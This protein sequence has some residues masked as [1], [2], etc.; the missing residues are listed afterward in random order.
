M[1]LIR[2]DGNNEIGTGHVMRCLSIAAQAER[3]EDVLFVVADDRS[4]ELVLKKGFPCVVLNTDY[5]NMEA[6]LP[7]LFEL[8]RKMNSK[9][10]LVDSYQITE[11]YLMKLSSQVS[12]CLIEDFM[13]T[14]HSVDVLVNYNIYADS[15]AYQT[16]YQMELKRRQMQLLLGAEYSP[17]REQ[18][19]EV[20]YTVNEQVRNVLITTGGS[21]PLQMGVR[22]LKE[23]LQKYESREL[24]YH[25]LSGIFDRSK[26]ELYQI[27]SRNKQVTVHENVT[28]M[29]ELMKSCDIAI[30]AAGTT[31]YELSAVG[32]PT[33]AYA[34][35]DNQDQVAEEFA[36][37]HM[38]LYAG[39]S[40]TDDVMRLH[41]I[42]KAFERML[43]DYD[44]RCEL[45]MEMKKHVDGA[46]ARKIYHTLYGGNKI[47]T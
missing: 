12:V 33:I 31:M 29:A 26:E 32:I 37:E 38:A 42:I 27:A 16:L 2:T 24:S 6:E 47:E 41:D 11:E 34:F 19:Q 5:T 8:I 1:I 13:T 35:V 15:E 39:G 40:K 21:D 10:I 17:L 3:K 7:L 45:H 14:S 30:S 25:I 44:L 22:I 28:E 18:F 43:D 4:A 23:M 36:K 9:K 20:T 46:G